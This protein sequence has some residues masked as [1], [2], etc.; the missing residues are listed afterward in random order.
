MTERQPLPAAA[1][2]PRRCAE[3][4]RIKEEYAEATRA[5]DLSRA[6]DLTVLM[7]RHLRRAHP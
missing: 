7:G 6:T 5:G 3:C 4:S 2:P 1:E